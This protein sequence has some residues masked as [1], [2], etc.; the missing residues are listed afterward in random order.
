MGKIL[1]RNC[2]EIPQLIQEVFALC[3]VPKRCPMARPPQG[4]LLFSNLHQSLAPR[5]AIHPGRRSSALPKFETVA[6][7]SS[8]DADKH[9]KRQIVNASTVAIP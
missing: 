5:R 9:L 6:K 4:L 8:P 1:T 2:V 7:V 3:R